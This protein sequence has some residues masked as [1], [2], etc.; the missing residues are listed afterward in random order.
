MEQNKIKIATSTPHQLGKLSEHYESG[1]RG[2]G[3]VSG[4]QGDPGGVSYGLYQLASK[5][6]TAADFVKT[7]GAPWAKELAGIPGSAAFSAAWK[8]IAA[9]DGERFAQAQQ[10]FIAR[11]HYRPVVQAVLAATQHDLDARPDAVRDACWSA[12]VQHGAAAR[13]LTGAVGDAD[14][15]ATRGQIDHD[16]AT[17]TAAYKRR[18]AYVR[19][20]A[21]K[22][23][24][25][26]RQTLMNVVEK[27]YPSELSAALAMLALLR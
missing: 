20:I 4:G 2:P 24:G 25:A 21:D 10:D 3:A 16:R 19:A 6:G 9:R 7:E 5:T 14:A 22:S 15:L 17:I 27:R 13:L 12:A 1:G 26:V 23:R 11:S 8:A 18:S